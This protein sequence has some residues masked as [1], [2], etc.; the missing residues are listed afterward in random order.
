VGVTCCPCCLAGGTTR[1]PN[2]RGRPLY[3]SDVET[4]PV[5]HASFPVNRGRFN[6]FVTTARLSH[7]TRAVK[8]TASRPNPTN[9]ACSK[10]PIFENSRV[11][12]VA[13]VEARSSYFCYFGMTNVPGVTCERPTLTWPGLTAGRKPGIWLR[14]TVLAFESG[15]PHFQSCC[16][17][18][19][20]PHR[21]WLLCGISYKML[22]DFCVLLEVEIE[23]KGKRTTRAPRSVPHFTISEYKLLEE[24]WLHDWNDEAMDTFLR[25]AG[26][27]QRTLHSSCANRLLFKSVL[28]SPVS[29]FNKSESGR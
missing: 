16:F 11:C 17:I 8:W 24:S 27:L 28:E 19:K 6:V 3:S 18:S 25:T 4:L 5:L 26:I 20:P 9:R 23:V 12:I 21:R 2:E 22:K 7:F 13:A 10:Q 15:M 14:L 29:R 1:A